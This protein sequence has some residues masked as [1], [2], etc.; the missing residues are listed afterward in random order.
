MNIIDKLSIGIVGVANLT[1]S[2]TKE[3][4]AKKAVVT[5]EQF[6]SVGILGYEAELWFYWL[7]IA[8]TVLVVGINFVKAVCGVKA[9]FTSRKEESATTN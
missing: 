3:A 2:G 9:Y 7:V 8:S 6:K 1:L 5:V 4:T